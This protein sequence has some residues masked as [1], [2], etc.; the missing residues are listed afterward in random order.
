M[1]L[2]EARKR[3]NKKWNDANGAKRYDRI[4]LVVEKGKKELIKAHAAAYGASVNDFINRAIEEKIERD[5]ADKS[6]LRA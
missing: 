5:G 6:A 1:P 3:A 4:H 2:S